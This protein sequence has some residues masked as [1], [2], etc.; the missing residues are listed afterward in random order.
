MSISSL[1]LFFFYCLQEPEV[2]IPPPDYPGLEYPPVFEPG[3]Y[4]LDASTLLP[5]SSKQPKS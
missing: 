1:S 3:T 4:T 5:R 2:N